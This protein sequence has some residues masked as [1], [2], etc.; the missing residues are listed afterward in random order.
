MQNIPSSPGAP[1]YCPR[2][3][4]PAIWGDIQ[5][6]HSSAYVEKSYKIGMHKWKY[7]IA[8]TICFR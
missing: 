7:K 2:R 5:F 6:V 4:T 1:R 3:R 8:H